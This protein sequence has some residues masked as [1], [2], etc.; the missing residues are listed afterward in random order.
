[1]LQTDAVTDIRTSIHILSLA[2]AELGWPPNGRRM[3]T[4]A[5][6]AWMRRTCIAHL[7][8]A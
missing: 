4:D 6:Q 8:Q 1:M 2:F 5:V 7:D 3:S